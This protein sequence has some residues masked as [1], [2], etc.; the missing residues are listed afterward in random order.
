MSKTFWIFLAAGIGVVGVL[1]SG[2]LVGTKSAH[3][4]LT[5]SILK[6]RVLPV[7]ASASLVVAD[8]RIANPSA[9]PFVV[10]DVEMQLER[11]SGEPAAA[12]IVSKQQ[13]ETIFKAR[14]LLGAKY[15]DVLGMQDK[16]LGG[17]T[18]DRMV[19]GRIEL[20]EAAINARKGL[21][22]R[23]EDVDGTVAE[24]T[25]KQPGR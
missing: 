18:L 12:M 3:L 21:R 6:V 22:L 10:R 8:F 15:N 23:I 19:A 4:E 5:G 25:E 20:G 24:I 7:G 9:V 17:Q 2:L 14:T 1:V 11:T 16:I 13:M